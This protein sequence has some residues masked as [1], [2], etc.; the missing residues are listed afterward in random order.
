MNLQLIRTGFACAMLSAAFASHADPVLTVS[1]GGG[2]LANVDVATGTTTVLGNTGTVLT[3]IA[4]SPTGDLF[5]ISFNGL[6]KV[7][8]TTGATIL[9]GSLGWA[10]TANALVF[11]S[12]GT[13]Y[14][15]S[16]TLY[17]V[18]TTSATTTAIGSIGFQSGGDLAFVGGNLYMA[19]D[20][21]VVK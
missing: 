3:D 15:A 12:D 14:M 9:V 19:S 18:S 10:G 7:N 4:F 17:T 2:Q 5:G 20:S 11:G 21:V 13:L 1:T 8:P 16:N 6:Y